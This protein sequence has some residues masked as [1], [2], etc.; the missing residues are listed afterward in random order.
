MPDEPVDVTCA[1]PVCG[2]RI[3]ARVE[4]ATRTVEFFDLGL[5]TWGMS[6]DHA[7]SYELA[8]V[9]NERAIVAA[10]ALGCEA[11]VS[12]AY[13]AAGHAIAAMRRNVPF[14]E[15]TL[16][17]GVDLA[18]A[19]AAVTDPSLT[20]AQRRRRARRMIEVCLAGHEA[21]RLLATDDGRIC[22]GCVI[23]AGAWT[24]AG[25]SD[26]KAF[27]ASRRP[28]MRRLMVDRAARAHAIARHLIESP[29]LSGE[30]IRRGP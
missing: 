28:R 7:T 20:V 15:V 6:P 12:A 24:L 1:C 3:R 10:A 14:T 8:V 18:L 16:D 30:R 4:R 27:T 25:V 21:E 29:T 5:C 2:E 23:D 9:R 26:P 19:I 13:H 22:A 17:G 11:D